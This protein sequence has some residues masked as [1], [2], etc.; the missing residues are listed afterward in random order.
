MFRYH[1]NVESEGGADLSF[2]YVSHRALL[3][4]EVI[5]ADPERSYVVVSVAHITSRDPLTGDVFG[6]VT[7]RPTE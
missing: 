7:A 1:V 5:R 2:R 6:S 3:S 4:G